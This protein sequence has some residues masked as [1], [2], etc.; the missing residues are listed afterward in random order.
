M[1]WCV[2]WWLKVDYST[3]VI[4]VFIITELS[5]ISGFIPQTD[6]KRTFFF[7]QVAP[8]FSLRHAS[9]LEM[10]EQF[11]RGKLCLFALVLNPPHPA[12]EP[13]QI[14]DAAS[15][16]THFCQVKSSCILLQPNIVLK[17][18]GVT[19]S[20]WQ[21]DYFPMLVVS[22]DWKCFTTRAI[23]RIKRTMKLWKLPNQ[24]IFH[25][26]HMQLHAS[27]VQ[28]GAQL[29][30]AVN[31]F[32]A[33][34]QQPCKRRSNSV[35]R[36]LVQWNQSWWAERINEEKRSETYRSVASTSP[37]SSSEDSGRS[38][39]VS[40]KS[41]RCRVASGLI[42]VFIIIVTEKKTDIFMSLI[43]FYWLNQWAMHKCENSGVIGLRVITCF[44]ILL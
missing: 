21:T 38:A 28:C 37:F 39:C 43:C 2:L 18:A 7:L 6:E 15:V 24:H 29:K 42:W 31:V 22:H 20:R 8:W 9:T 44:T 3:C 12:G 16:F 40:L 27:A 4:F 25:L 41:G 1:I 14:R 17:L 26:M 36:C 23:C 33:I 11:K 30:W 35:E 19:I 32:A 34:C 13:W 10:L 5:P